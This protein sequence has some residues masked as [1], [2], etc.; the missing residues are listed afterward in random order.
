[1]IG[2]AAQMCSRSTK[3]PSARGRDLILIVVVNLYLDYSL[4][5]T[6]GVT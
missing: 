5:A 6:G 4:E 3:A 2:K 1:M